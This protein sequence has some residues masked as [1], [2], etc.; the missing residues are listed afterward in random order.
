[1]KRYIN[2]DKMPA[3]AR[4]VMKKIP[5][6]ELWKLMSDFAEGY[7]KPND[8]NKGY[9]MEGDYI[10]C[11]VLKILVTECESVRADFSAINVDTGNIACSN[12]SFFGDNV[13]GSPM[14]GLQSAS[15]GYTFFGFEC[16]GDWEYPIFGII[17]YD[18][19]KLR[20]YIPSCGNVV[21]LD[22]HC[23]LGSEKIDWDNEIKVQK[24]MDIYSKVAAENP[25]RGNISR[26]DLE[27]DSNLEKYYMM[28]Y[29]M[30]EEPDSFGYN[31]ELIEKDIRAMFKL[32]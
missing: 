25:D 29:G 2:D 12:D 13:V 4:K 3:R 27:D 20:A 5:K 26:E 24:Y 22:F 21:N 6:E 30:E 10:G 15:D 23:A 17:Y 31:W 7:D 18:G 11:S 8:I 9:E 16:G 28:K 32:I 19:A 1:M 14:L